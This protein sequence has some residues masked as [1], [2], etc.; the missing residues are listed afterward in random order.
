MI[1]RCGGWVQAPSSCPLYQP[2][3][4]YPGWTPLRR[5]A[6]PGSSI[7]LSQYGPRYGRV[8]SYADLS[9]RYVEEHTRHYASSQYQRSYQIRPGHLPSTRAARRYATAVPVPARLGA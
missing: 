8:P 3:S 1:P 6:L 5:L 7:A 2:A 4:P 9:S